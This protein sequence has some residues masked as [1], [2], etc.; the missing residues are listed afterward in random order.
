MLGR[1][2]FPVIREHFRNCRALLFPGEEDFGIVPVEAMAS[3]R[4]VI[5]FG[6][7]GALET[8]MEGKTGLFFGAQT[9]ESLVE[10]VERFEGLESTFDSGEIIRHAAR[11]DRA[12]FKR[13]IGERIADL[14]EEHTRRV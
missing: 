1:Q 3:G 7:G 10:A 2:P 9:V 8:V 12:V 13:K 14:L 6:R 5:A 11:F 4:P